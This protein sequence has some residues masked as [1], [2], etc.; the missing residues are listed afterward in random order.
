MEREGGCVSNTLIIG[1]RSTTYCW[2]QLHEPYAV[3]GPLK[4]VSRSL[5]KLGRLGDWQSE[6]PLQGMFVFTSPFNAAKPY[7]PIQIAAV[8]AGKPFCP[9]L[10]LLRNV[11]EAFPLLKRANNLAQQRTGPRGG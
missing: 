3:L 11:H 1:N 2:D 9:N 8:T 10:E 4:D 5:I 6:F 7:L